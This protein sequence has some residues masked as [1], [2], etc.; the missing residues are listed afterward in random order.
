MA[1][2]GELGVL[3]LRAANQQIS[4]ADSEEPGET[5]LKKFPPDDPS[6]MRVRKHELV[7]ARSEKQRTHSLNKR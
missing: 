5:H 6:G 3:G 1:C 4:Q 2:M 7:L